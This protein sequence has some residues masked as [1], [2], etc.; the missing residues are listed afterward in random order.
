MSKEKD[1][2]IEAGGQIFANEAFAAIAT[3]VQ[4]INNRGLR[5]LQ[6]EVNRNPRLVDRLGRF[7]NISQLTGQSA[8]IPSSI[9]I[10][11]SLNSIATNLAVD[12]FSGGDARTMPSAQEMFRG[13]DRGNMIATAI[14]EELESC[15]KK[16]KRLLNRLSINLSKAKREILGGQNQLSRLITNRFRA[17]R[18][19]IINSYLSEKEKL[20]EYTNNLI[21]EVT[22]NLIERFEESLSETENR[23]IERFSSELDSLERNLT[24]TLES[25]LSSIKEDLNIRF[26]S[27]DRTTDATA[28]DVVGIATELT[29]LNLGFTAFA[30]ESLEAQATLLTTTIGDFSTTDL[31][32]GGISKEIAVKSIMD[33]R[34]F[35]NFF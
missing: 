31:A 25:E 23:L 19:E 11:G 14:A 2:E 35:R 9:P 1:P 29:E 3:E 33:T 13:I 32:I 26:S 8:G 16:I 10:V 34:K 17:L 24:H 27:L 5:T 30:T 4:T 22:D 28:V 21:N 6:R 20:K 18:N 12:V 7:S 15:C